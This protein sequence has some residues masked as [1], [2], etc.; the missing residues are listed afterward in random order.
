M[1][2]KGITRELKRLL[3]GVQRLEEKGYILREQALDK[4]PKTEKALKKVKPRDLFVKNRRVD[5]DTGE[6]WYAK[7]YKPIKPLKQNKKPKQEEWFPQFHEIVISNYKAHISQFNERAYTL[8]NSWLDRIIS[9][10]GEEQAAIMLNDGAENGEIVTYQIV[11]SSDRLTEYMANML[12]YLPEAGTLFKEQ[13]V[14]AFEY[15]ED[16]ESPQ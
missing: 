7:N 12:E 14:E 6:V 2:E 16:W 10:V 1:S 3:R 13:M 4:L 11:Y 15:L 5:V 9:S 8:L